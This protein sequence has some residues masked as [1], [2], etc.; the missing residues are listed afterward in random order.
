MTTFCSNCGTPNDETGNFC[1]KCG[2]KLTKLEPNHSA[3]TQAP[4]AVGKA[5]FSDSSPRPLNRDKEIQALTGVGGWLKFFCISNI[6]IGPFLAIGAVAGVS[7]TLTPLIQQ[8]PAF[9]TLI[10]LSW[11]Q[12]IGMSA[13]SIMM[14]IKLWREDPNALTWAKNTLVAAPILIALVSVAMVSVDGLPQAS[15]NAMIPEAVKGVLQSVFVCGIW[16]WYLVKSKRVRY[17][18]PTPE[19]HVH[20]PDCR[21]LNYRLLCKCP[22]CGTALIPQ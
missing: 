7:N 19:H 2:G 5:G 15:I 18:Y 11:A 20:C 21:K 22:H 17:T 8:V 13:L 16:Y 1:F 9:S 12:A 6:F 3:Q 10:S 14:G 4:I